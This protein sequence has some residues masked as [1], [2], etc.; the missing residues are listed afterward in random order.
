MM[1]RNLDRRVE[2]MVPVA[3]PEIKAR[4]DRIVELMLS[5]DRRS[6][7]LGSD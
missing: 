4:L 3:D 7:Q 6:W 5:D 1:E 2:A